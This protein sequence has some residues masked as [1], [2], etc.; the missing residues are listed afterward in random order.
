LLLFHG[1][2]DLRSQVNSLS[3]SADVPGL[4]GAAQSTPAI[5]LCIALPWLWPL[6]GGPTA[7]VL[8]W[9]VSA[10]SAIVLVV[11]ATL[12][13]SRLSQA[14]SWGWML[15]AL[16]SSGIAFVQYFGVSPDL[17]PWV[18]IAP[19]GEAFGN[20]R[21]RNHF[22]TLVNIGLAV[23]MFYL[24]AGKPGWQLDADNR[25]QRSGS[26]AAAW[27][28]VVLA[29]ATALALAAANAATLSRTGLFQLVTL[30]LLLLVWRANLPRSS[31]WVFV[32][33]VLAY[34]V[35]S[36]ALPM[37]IG[38]DP[39]TDG[40]GSRF[41]SPELACAG[42]VLLW[43][44]VLHL[45]AQKPWWGWGWGEVSY[46]HFM[47]LYPAGRFCDI[48]DNAH[49]LPLHLAVVWGIPLAVLLC[50]SLAFWVLRA[51]P[52]R[53]TVPARQMAWAVLAMIGLH[54]MLEYPLWY[55]PFQIATGLAIWMLW[56][57]RPTAAMVA[58]ADDGSAGT[59]Q[60]RQRGPGSPALV[61]AGAALS[62]VALTYAAWDYH[63]VSQV[64]KAPSL[65]S[66]AYRDDPLGKVQDSWLFRNQ[67]QFAVL[68]LSTVTPD[69]AQTLN[70]LAR[71]LLHFSPEAR[72][73]EK[74][75]DSDLVLGRMGDAAYYM[76]R[77]RRAFP[78]EYARWKSS[79]TH[80]SLPE[81]PPLDP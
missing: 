63:R 29:A 57:T 51:K 49:N 43:Q 4:P 72:V 59:D 18:N 13:R 34:V 28:T 3:T 80:A 33:A 78:A 5:A 66:S 26:H 20:L 44:N 14:S 68:T 36:M 70:A 1:P 76:L 21:Q 30:G 32:A 55:G 71:Q 11:L 10:A 7:S 81:L 56:R 23:A 31:N 60:A 52:W 42:R 27:P 48:L 41:R 61:L 35:A 50:G 64:Y 9:L 74:L 2:N 39:F 45:I 37:L 53:E 79:S 47:T 22:A 58:G 12:M 15:A 19:L 62:L 77:F 73:V 6:A 8:P 46:A 67:V 16:L 69:N 38:R 25:Q 40:L 54:S 65:R 24:V 17:Q 75:I